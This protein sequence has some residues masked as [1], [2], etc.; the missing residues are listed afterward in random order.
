MKPLHKEEE[1]TQENAFL[2]SFE[3][4]NV[5]KIFSFMAI[6]ISLEK[7]LNIDSRL[8]YRMLFHAS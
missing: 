3:I 8:L 1:K 5:Y 4:T 6:F 2:K 7:I